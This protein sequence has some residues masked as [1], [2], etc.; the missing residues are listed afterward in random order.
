MYKPHHSFFDPRATRSR[1]LLLRRIAL[2]ATHL[3][4]LFSCLSSFASSS[5]ASRPMNLNSSPSS[6]DSA[7]PQ[8]P[9]LEAVNSD[10]GGGVSSG[11]SALPFSRL[12]PSTTP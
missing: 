10:A 8:L 11:V 3:G 9:L 12:A 4:A 2:S 6:E 5:S 7:S 1:C